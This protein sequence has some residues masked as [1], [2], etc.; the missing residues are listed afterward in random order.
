MQ[1][2]R[3]GL[4]REDGCGGV[5]VVPAQF[6]GGKFGVAAC[7]RVGGLQP[8]G[9]VSGLSLGCCGRGPAFLRGGC[10][11]VVKPGQ[12]GIGRVPAGGVR[13]VEFERRGF[14]LCLGQQQ[15]K[16]RIEACHL[17]LGRLR[18]PG[19][20][21]FHGFKALGAEKALQQLQAVGCLGAQERREVAL[22][23]HDHA[24]ELLPVH[25]QDVGDFGP[26]LVI[27]A[28]FLH[29]LAVDAFA[30]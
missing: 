27:P 30:Q 6:R 23:Q 26:G 11:G 14:G 3:D 8:G 1:A 24:R 9:P 5:G 10:R 15:V 18:L 25:A 17:R 29:P 2:Q 13:G 19:Q 16:P 22:R 12:E 7:P 4:F 21:L 20:F 28:G